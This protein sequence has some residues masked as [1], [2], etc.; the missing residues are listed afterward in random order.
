[1]F[2]LSGLDFPKD[3][4]SLVSAI[5]Q[6]L[7]PLGLRAGR[8]RCEG[9]FPALSLLRC[10]LS[11]AVFRSEHRAATAA[12]A[13]QSGFFARRAEVV[14]DG[15]TLGGLGFSAT[16]TLDDAVFA[17]ARDAAGNPLL[18]LEQCGAGVMELEVTRSEFEKLVL[19]L[20][21]KAA[22]EHGAEVK[23]VTATWEPCG[24][25]A[26]SLRV[27]ARAKAMFMETSVTARGRVEVS[28]AL[29]IGV[30]GLSCSGEGMVGNLAASFLRKEIP[31][32]EGRSVS[33]AGTFG[34]VRLKD[35]TLRCEPDVLRVRASAA[36]A[37]E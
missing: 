31:K 15:A 30:S 2:L 24:E 35:V 13:T 21:A 4:A 28:D 7:H 27:V 36:P 18:A 10:D 11:G 8:V 34:G 17:F 22:E 14:C 33:L 25:R 37:V 12:G 23:A 29:A 26:I 16:L 6:G 32:Y 5:D 1:M 9:A 20:A 19:S 3:E